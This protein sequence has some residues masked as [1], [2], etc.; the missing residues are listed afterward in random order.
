MANL[1]L[2]S[3]ELKQL[4]QQLKTEKD[5]QFLGYNLNLGSGEFSDT[6]EKEPNVMETYAVT[7]LLRHYLQGTPLVMGGKLIKFEELP[8]GHSYRKAF[9]ERAISPITQNFGCYPQGLV[10]AAKRLGGKQLGFGDASVDIPTIGE[11]SLVYVLWAEGEFPSSANVLFYE[12]A[13]SHLPTEDLAVL[14]ELTSHR[15]L[16]AH[17]CHVTE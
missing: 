4:I 7:I 5:Y 6:F 14:G 1:K 9:G 16:K 15:L 3:E 11:I 8:G 13:N 10:D 2:Q 12:S 17:N